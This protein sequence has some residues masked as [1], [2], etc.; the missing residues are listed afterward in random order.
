M[1]FIGCHCTLGELL[2]SLS[3]YELLLLLHL[4]L[5]KLVLLL[6]LLL[7]EVESLL[8]LRVDIKLLLLEIAGACKS[9]LRILV[10]QLLLFRSDWLLT[11]YLVR[12]LE[13]RD[14]CGDRL[15]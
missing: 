3:L 11:L 15:L 5:L 14:I 13:V 9:E 1:I 6:K 12:V 10:S 2:L 7:L 4:Y 8:T